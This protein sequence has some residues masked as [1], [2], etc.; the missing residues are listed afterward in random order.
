MIETAPATTPDG[1]EEAMMP[2]RNMDELPPG[3]GPPWWEEMSA[4]SDREHVR[5]EI[6]R[7]IRAGLVTVRPRP[8]DPE[9]VEVVPRR[10]TPNPPQGGE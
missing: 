3:D 5:E 8:G 10:P 2:K 1:F 9:R 4:T 7:L 6:A